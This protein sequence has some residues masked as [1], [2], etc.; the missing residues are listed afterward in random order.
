[1]ISAVVGSN[2]TILMLANHVTRK[3]IVLIPNFAGKPTS[4]KTRTLNWIFFA[5]GSSSTPSIS[6]VDTFHAKKS[7][8]LLSTMGLSRLET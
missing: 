3:I 4:L 8:C 2:P 1:L 7:L 6:L 5:H